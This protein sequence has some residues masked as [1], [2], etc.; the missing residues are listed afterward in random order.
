MGQE[1]E[2]EYNLI[3]KKDLSLIKIKLG[4]SHMKEADWKVVKDILMSH[5]VI[6]AVPQKENSR[7]K[8]VENILY[9]NHY[10]IVFTNTWDCK[11]HIFR[12][13]YKQRMWKRDFEATVIP[14]ETA[15]DIANRN[16]LDLFIDLQEE[17]NS[18][19]IC[20]LYEMKEFKAL[21]IAVTR[22]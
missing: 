10:L 22:L 5:N 12:L 4:K 16:K 3:S 17:I 6:S 8:G 18:M 20:Y 11:K 7:V 13:N 21:R 2:T 15:I 1:Y 19:C 14:F 9:E